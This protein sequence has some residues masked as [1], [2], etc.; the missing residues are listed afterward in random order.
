MGLINRSQADR[1]LGSWLFEGK[2]E[3]HLFT[4]IHQ[5]MVIYLTESSLGKFF[6]PNVYQFALCFI[7]FSRR[8]S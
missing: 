7:N 5:T 6:Q 3:I 1:L 2:I 8:N 4:E